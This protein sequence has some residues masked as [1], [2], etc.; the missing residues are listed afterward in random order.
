MKKQILLLALVAIFFTACKKDDNVEV[1]ETSTAQKLLG[2]WKIQSVVYNN[3]FNG[4]DHINTQTGT[5]TDFFEFRN[6]GKVYSQ[7]QNSYD[8]TVYNV[9]TNNT[10]NIEGLI[11]EIK[12]LTA[13]QLK[14]YN[15]ITISTTPLAYDEI[16]KNYFK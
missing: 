3:F 9:P 13:T 15:K 1:P 2:V 10:V 14:L 11:F 8:S 4:A 16:T 12:T 6:N 7:F 5:A